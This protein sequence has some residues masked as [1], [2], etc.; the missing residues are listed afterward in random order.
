MEQITDALASSGSASASE[1][2]ID[3]TRESVME[4]DDAVGDHVHTS[5]RLVT[6][7]MPPLSLAPN[8]P[9]DRASQSVASTCGP[10]GP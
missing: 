1:R 7:V 3:L 9:Y 4:I 2:T 8:D 5:F 10:G 6:A